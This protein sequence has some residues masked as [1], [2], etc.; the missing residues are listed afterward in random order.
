MDLVS[1]IETGIRTRLEWNETFRQGPLDFFGKKPGDYL[2]P[3]LF[4][5]S[6]GTP[7]IPE[8][9]G[10]A[11]NYALETLGVIINFGQFYVNT[12]QLSVNQQLSFHFKKNQKQQS[13]YDNPLGG[14]E[15]FEYLTEGKLK[16]TVANYDKSEEKYVRMESQNLNIHRHGGWGERNSF[17]EVGAS[18][19]ES[20]LLHKDNFLKIPGIK[21]EDHLLFQELFALI[22]SEYKSNKL[23]PMQWFYT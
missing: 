16:F 18:F 15:G 5:N 13:D 23:E 1:R 22:E 9:I 8:N 20:L 21:I 12:S 11:F 19:M 6:N 17:T 4:V 3:E 10:E 7:R 14:I 2:D